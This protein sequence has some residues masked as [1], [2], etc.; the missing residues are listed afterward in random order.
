MNV[1]KL[2]PVKLDGC[3]GEEESM[4]ETG[5]E[6]VFIV[7]SSIWN[8]LRWKG[9]QMERSWRIERIIAYVSK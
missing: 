2:Q 9:A 3:R 7:G 4:F 8:R 6:K 5:K 1:F